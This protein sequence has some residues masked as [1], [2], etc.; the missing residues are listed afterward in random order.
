MVRGGVLKLNTPPR[1]SLSV[2]VRVRQGERELPDFPQRGVA[3]QT[4]H[5]LAQVCII[6]I[7]PIIAV[8]GAVAGAGAA[9]EWERGETKILWSEDSYDGR[10]RLFDVRN[11]SEYVL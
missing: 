6:E 7:N 10:S 3:R 2:R 1:F 4:G 9:I 8:A 11:W 5:N